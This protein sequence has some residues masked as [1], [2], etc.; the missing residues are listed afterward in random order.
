MSR[1]GPDPPPVRPKA[2]RSGFGSMVGRKPTEPRPCIVVKGRGAAPER[3]QGGEDPLLERARLLDEVY[4]VQA[5]KANKPRTEI[6]A[7]GKV[8]RLDLINAAYPPVRQG[9]AQVAFGVYV[10]IG[11]NGRRVLER[12]VPPLGEVSEALRVQQLPLMRRVLAERLED[13]SPAV[14]DA[15]NRIRDFM[16]RNHPPAGSQGNV[17]RLFKE[18]AGYKL[19][20]D[21]AKGLASEADMLQ[22]FEMLTFFATCSDCGHRQYFAN[23]IYNIDTAWDRVHGWAG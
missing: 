10:S 1:L 7:G 15:Y 18:P 20:R 4:P 5:L 23:D 3:K 17:R 9:T 12:H 8:A 13:S 19:A 2:P 22:V 6:T 16:E 21:A 14:V 11:P